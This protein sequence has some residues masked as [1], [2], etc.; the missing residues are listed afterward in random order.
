MKLAVAVLLAGVS[1]E[2]G[3][4][5][6]EAAIPPRMLSGG[7]SIEGVLFFRRNPESSCSTGIVLD[8]S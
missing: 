5:L 1:E 8:D 3:A 7:P 6:E 2:E 4:A